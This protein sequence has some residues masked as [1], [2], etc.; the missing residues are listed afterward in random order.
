MNWAMEHE[1]NGKRWSTRGSTRSWSH[2]MMTPT[3]I[4][5]RSTSFTC[6]GMKPECLKSAPSPL[7][8]LDTVVKSNLAIGSFLFYFSFLGIW[9]ISGFWFFNCF[10][11]RRT[12]KRPGQLWME[13]NGMEWNEKNIFRIFF[14]PSCLGVLTEKME[15]SFPCL[16]V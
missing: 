4:A 5:G 11:Q 16:R 12:C 15:S 3:L 7:S 1:N 8:F 10:V 14:P 6:L 2:G 13:M 9:L